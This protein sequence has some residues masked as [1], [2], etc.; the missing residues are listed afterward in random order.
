MAASETSAIMS[1]I[2]TTDTGYTTALRDERR[3]G[4]KLVET[5]ALRPD[6]HET[7]YP[8][9]APV[10]AGTLYYFISHSNVHSKIC[11]FGPG[12]SER[13]TPTAD[14]QRTFCEKQWRR[15]ESP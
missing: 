8:S 10:R 5:K 14:L 11:N 15:A 9:N 12:S 6:H 7:N 3:R 2:Y 1:K 4:V 13:S